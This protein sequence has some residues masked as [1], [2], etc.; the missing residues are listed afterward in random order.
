MTITITSPREE[1]VTALLKLAQELGMEVSVQADEASAS[2]EAATDIGARF[3]WDKS[4]ALTKGMG[5]P[6]ASQLLIE[7]RESDWR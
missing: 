2:Q 6:P 3:N 1:A 4:L 7:E 5:G